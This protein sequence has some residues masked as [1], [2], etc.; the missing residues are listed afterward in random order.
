MDFPVLDEETGQLME[1]RQLRKHPKYA[2]NWTTSYSNE[3]SRICQGIG[4]ITEGTEQC[5]QGTYTF[6][7]INYHN[8]PDNRHKE[9]TYTSVV[10]EVRPQKEDPNRTRITIGVNHI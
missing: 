1:Y 8:I 5:I 10:C 2:A 4:K 7:V 6:F 9:I 3:M